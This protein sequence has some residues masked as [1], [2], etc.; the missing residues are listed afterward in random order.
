M[1]S[2]FL[3]D[4]PLDYYATLPEGYRKVTSAEVETAAKAQIEEEE[5]EAWHRRGSLGKLHNLVTGIRRTP[6]RREKFN[7]QP[8]LQHLSADGIG[9]LYLA[10]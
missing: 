10:A 2:L 1:T 9:E 8:E 3:Y 4:R 6:Q 5:L 7:D